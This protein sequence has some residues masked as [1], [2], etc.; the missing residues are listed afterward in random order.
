MVLFL[1]VQTLHREKQIRMNVE[2][3]RAQIE[4][5]CDSRCT[6]FIASASLLAS[7]LS[8]RSRLGFTSP[9]RKPSSPCIRSNVMQF[10][11]VTWLLQFKVRENTNYPPSWLSVCFLEMGVLNILLYHL[12]TRKHCSLSSL[13]LSFSHTHL[14]MTFLLQIF[15]HSIS[16]RCIT[17]SSSDGVLIQ[18]ILFT[19]NQLCT[20]HRMTRSSRCVPVTVKTHLHFNCFI[21]DTHHVTV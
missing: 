12:N 14:W 8:L 7:S 17:H 9:S 15:Q 13:L 3:Q 19:I 16:A 2:T 4:L 21:K 1:A 20:C 11:L 10:T 18:I 6:S 5:N